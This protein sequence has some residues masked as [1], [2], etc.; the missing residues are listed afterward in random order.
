MAVL[1]NV[2]QTYP[3]VI[4]QTIQP[5]SQKGIFS[6]GLW[7]NGELVKINVDADLPVYD[8]SSNVLTNAGFG[9]K[10]CMWVALIEKAY[11]MIRS[12]GSY[13]SLTAGWMDEADVALGGTAY[14]SYSATSAIT[15]L[16]AID[17]EVSAG[18]AVTYSTNYIPPG[19]NLVEAHAY[20]VVSVI[21][22]K[23]GV[24]TS[25]RLRNPWGTDGYYVKD[26]A[27]DGYVTVTAKQAFLSFGAYV[28]AQF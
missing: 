16:K 23:N 9:S 20:S 8:G 25:L 14:K 4:K 5:T 13:D 17:T 10:G 15:L 22:D 28:V 7:H 26:G 6:V 18:K 19:V 2:A 24:P 1:S 11:A 3:S 12:D 27:D 21:K